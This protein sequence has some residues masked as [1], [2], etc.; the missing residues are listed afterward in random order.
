MRDNE[1]HGTW[2]LKLRAD[3]GHIYRSSDKYLEE[4]NNYYT[5][6]IKHAAVFDSKSKAQ[7][8]A[9]DFEAP[10]KMDH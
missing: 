7:S 5:N 4:T 6:N 3:V 2:V 8:S 10:V 9:H 1:L